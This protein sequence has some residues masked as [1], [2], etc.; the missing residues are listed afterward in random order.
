MSSTASTSKVNTK[1]PADKK[2]SK[3][4]DVTT[5]APAAAAPP[6]A[7]PAPK[8]AAVKKTPA[9]KSEVTVP[10]VPATSAAPAVATTVISSDAQLTTL[11]EQLKALS[12]EFSSK[13]R[14]A[15]KGIQAAAVQA[16]REARDSKK[17]RKV[18]PA[19]LSPEARVI[20]E[21]RR[22]NN[23]F[24]KQKPLS[25]ELCQFMGLATKSKRSQTEVTKFVSEYVKAHSCYDPSF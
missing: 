2:V 5:P 8:K 14:E 19:T 21:A 13:V 17:K 10:T 20:W 18:D 1:M 4:A 24:L 9:A 25:D 6:T 12:V 15:V 11:T 3:K 7:T 16:K 23:A 22:A